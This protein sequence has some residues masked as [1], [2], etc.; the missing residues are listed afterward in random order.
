MALFM[1]VVSLELLC[2][3]AKDKAMIKARSRVYEKSAWLGW[4]WICCVW[5]VWGVREILRAP[6]F[7]Y[8]DERERERERERD[9]ECMPAIGGFVVVGLMRGS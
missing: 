8:L 1:Y 5:I 4:C 6:P 9:Q 2:G 7:F 3:F